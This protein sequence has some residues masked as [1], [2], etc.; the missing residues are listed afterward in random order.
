M[1][2]FGAWV[3]ITGS[4]AG[5]GSHWPTCHGEI[6]PIEPNIKTIIEFTHRVTSGLLGILSLGFVFF[7]LKK[8]GL[9]PAGK[10]AIIT[11]IFI[12]VES[13]VGAGIVLKEL[14][15]DD[16]SVAR[17]TVI[18]FHLVNTLFLTGSAALAAHWYEREP[19][20]FKNSRHVI[21]CALAIVAIVITSITGAVTALGDTLFPITLET[22][23]S[24]FS[25]VEAGLDATNHFLVRLRIIHPIVA[26]L[27][28]I[29]VGYVCYWNMANKNASR[30]AK[31]GLAIAITQIFA[32][33]GNIFLGAPGYM[34][35]A[36]LFLAQALWICV[37]LM[38]VEISM[39]RKE[40][41]QQ[42]H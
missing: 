22:G 24:I 2:L 21:S 12:I 4:G 16:D 17:A 19:S 36:H 35:L 7:F 27:T 15:A 41:S 26:T 33:Y 28:A 18:A 14:V 42:H 13:L 20:P 29:G 32:G 31:L 6:I 37:V 38:S 1:I 40:A 34:Q 30:Y 25:N 11:L 10:A 23:H 8:W 5:C 9:K 3:R 39:P